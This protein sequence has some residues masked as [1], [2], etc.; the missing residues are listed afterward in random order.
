MVLF[1]FLN[2]VVGR[3]KGSE[4][5]PVCVTDLTSAEFKAPSQIT[6]LKK[7]LNG[8][9]GTARPAAK[10]GNSCVHGKL[11]GSPG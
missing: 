6:H 8:S 10:H 1:C 7:G 2:N 9:S 4:L 3:M 11:E 5:V